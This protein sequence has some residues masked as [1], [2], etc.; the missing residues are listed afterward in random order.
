VIGRL[1]SIN[2]GRP[3]EVAWR[4]R[5]VRTAVW[6]HPVPGPRM[7]RRLDVDGDDQ[8]D[9]VAHGGE[10]RAVLVYQA[11]SYRHWERVLGRRDLTP[12][13]FGENLTVEGLADDEVCIGDRLRIGEA[14][15]EVSQPRVTCYRV[16]IRLGVP[17]MPR[18]L[19]THRRPGFYLRV[20]TEGR[21]D[22]G[23]AVVRAAEG[24]GRVTVAEA[25]ALLYLPDPPRDR[26]RVAAG[27][28]AFSPGWRASLRALLDAPPE[29]AVPAWEGFRPMRVTARRAESS[30]IT[31]LSLAP[32]DGAP[33]AAWAPGQHV[34]LRLDPGG[35]RSPV[36]R[37]YSLSTG[38]DAGPG[39]RISVK[40]EPG[41]AASGHLHDAV[42]V[43]DVLDVAAPRGGFTLRPGSRPVVLLSAG[44]GATPV[45]AMLHALAAAGDARPVWWV[46]GARDAATRA[47]AAE[48]DGLLAR[49]PCGRRLVALSRPRPGVPADDGA[50][51]AG[52]LDAGALE[53]AGV[54]VD[55]DHYLCGPAG[56]L[57]DVRA[58][59]A[60]RGVPPAQVA[61]EVFGTLAA[62]A[63]GV[64]AGVPPA[65]HDPDGPPG[66]GPAVSFARSGLTVRWD[67]RFPS[68]LDL[69]EACAV[70]VGFGCRTG[71][72]HTCESSLLDGAVSYTSPPL[73]APPAGRVLVCCSTP[74]TDVVLDR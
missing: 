3:R 7:V 50:D 49:L 56:F 45:L 32:A 47:F 25:D 10:H 40:R 64:V 13:H 59:L 52:R 14:E 20:L 72:C 28:A 6:K 53:R 17:E 35:D 27:V 68:L 38:P 51:V 71:T 57:R 21:V 23:D 2:V 22:V 30:T 29:A 60:A 65:P 19:V 34:T 24:P 41:G 58:A 37:D 67:A 63:S 26:L 36:V 12:G 18:L 5:T 39:Y 73:Q 15:F 31:S 69:A 44:V 9:R 54:P 11:D 62:P 66:S 8:A 55:A 46:H 33:V 43:G 42:R 16:G 70:P 1:L 48:V 4:G 74:R 61:T